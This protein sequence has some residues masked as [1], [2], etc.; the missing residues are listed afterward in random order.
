MNGQS[1]LSGI[2]CG[3]FPSRLTTLEKIQSIFGVR[4]D[5]VGQTL[6]DELRIPGGL[7]RGAC[8]DIGER[9]DDPHADLNNGANVE[10]DY[11]PIACGSEQARNQQGDAGLARSLSQDTEELVEG[12]ELDD[13]SE[14]LGGNVIY[15]APSSDMCSP[16]GDDG[17]S[18]V[19]EPSKKHHKVVPAEKVSFDSD[20]A[21]G[22]EEDA[23]Y[24]KADPAQGQEACIVT[25]YAHGNV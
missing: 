17:S 16:G 11:P 21:P 22:D 8:E 19:E 15:M 18:Q 10:N 9:A 2:D 20:I 24:R 12:G 1:Q 23:R 6:A 25:R 5:T 7:D 4:T 13:E 14:S 3:V